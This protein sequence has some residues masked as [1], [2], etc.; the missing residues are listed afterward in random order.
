MNACLLSSFLS[1]HCKV[2]QEYARQ[3]GA[4]LLKLAGDSVATA[5]A[6]ARMEE[7]AQEFCSLMI[8]TALSNP[9]QLKWCHASKMDGS[10]EK[11]TH[12][13]SFWADLLVCTLACRNTVISLPAY[14]S[15]LSICCSPSAC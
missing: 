13:P 11:G 8:C 14:V 1:N 6:Q 5:T 3:I 2:L 7:L 9:E 10:N 4:C 15:H 12:P